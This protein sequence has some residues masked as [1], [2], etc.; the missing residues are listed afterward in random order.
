MVSLKLG[1]LG[2]GDIILWAIPC[3][4]RGREGEEREREGE[5][6]RDVNEQL[7]SS[8]YLML[9]VFHTDQF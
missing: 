2:Y 8:P 5:R 4:E 9:F 1:L 6:E 3:F 7:I